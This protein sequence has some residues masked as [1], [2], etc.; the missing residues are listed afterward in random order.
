MGIIGRTK[1]RGE[2]GKKGGEGMMLNGNQQSRV[3]V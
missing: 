3:L 2:F 1:E